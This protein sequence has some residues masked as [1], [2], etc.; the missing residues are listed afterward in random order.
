MQIKQEIH[1]NA[2]NRRSQK[3]Y[4]TSAAS[5]RCAIH[6]N[7]IKGLIPVWQ[8]LFMSVVQLQVHTNNTLDGGEDSIQEIFCH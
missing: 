6:C 1:V 8:C 2:Q 7:E 4:C 5:F 3:E